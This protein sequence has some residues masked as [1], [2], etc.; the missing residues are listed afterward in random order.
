MSIAPAADFYP[1]PVHSTPTNTVRAWEKERA[2]AAHG[3]PKPT[4]REPTRPPCDFRAAHAMLHLFEL[5]FEADARFSVLTPVPWTAKEAA[6]T[7]AAIRFN[8][9][10][11]D[12]IDRRRLNLSAEW[13]IVL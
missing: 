5:G 11:P 1:D 6:K 12:A 2:I 8:F 9:M 3:A 7:L 4:Y 13:E 10:A